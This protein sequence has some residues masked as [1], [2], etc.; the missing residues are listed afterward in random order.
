MVRTIVLMRKRSKLQKELN[1]RDLKNFNDIALYI[2][3]S[4][5]RPI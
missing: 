1:D 2:G 4:S 3:M 5:L